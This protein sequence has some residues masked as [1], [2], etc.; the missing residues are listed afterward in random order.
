MENI[1]FVL[2]SPTRRTDRGFT[3]VELLVVI[4]IIA[5]LIALLLPAIQAAREAAR[6][7]QCTNNLKQMALGCLNYASARKTLPPGKTAYYATDAGA[8]NSCGEPYNAA[9]WGILILPYIEGKSLYQMY[10]FELNPA[11]P[12]IPY[13]TSDPINAPVTQAFVDVMNCPS[14]P[15]PPSIAMPQNGNPPGIPFAS[16]SYKGVAG[17]GWWPTNSVEAFMDS[18]KAFPNEGLTIADRG[19]LSVIVGSNDSCF[20]AS[21]LKT[22]VK[23]TQ[24]KDGTSKTLLIGEYTTTTL[25]AAGLSRAAFWA[26]SYYSMSPSGLDAAHRLSDQPDGLQHARV[27]CDPRSGFSEMCERNRCH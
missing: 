4:A 15:N 5:I 6:R 3:L 17:R 21:M 16:G 10:H 25:P 26:D 24:I 13:Q 12:G 23:I 18:S 14:D 11:T 19:P 2:P 9:G 8:G 1:P 27:F 22:P 20:M 7:S